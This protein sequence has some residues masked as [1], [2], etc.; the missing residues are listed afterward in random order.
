MLPPRKPEQRVVI[1]ESVTGMCTVCV[2]Q[3]IVW[4]CLWEERFLY[5]PGRA[6]DINCLLLKVHGMIGF[7]DVMTCFFQ[8]LEHVGEIPTKLL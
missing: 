1:S 4:T 2:E 8:V 6:V 7:C 5:K 3:T